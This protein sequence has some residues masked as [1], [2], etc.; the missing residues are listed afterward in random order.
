MNVLETASSTLIA[1]YAEMIA[2]KT[3]QNV[4]IY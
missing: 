1:R 3:I 2:E 4:S